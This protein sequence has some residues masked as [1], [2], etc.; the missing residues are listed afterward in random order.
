MD[1]IVRETEDRIPAQ[2]IKGLVNWNFVALSKNMHPTK[3]E[4]SDGAGAPGY[5]HILQLSPQ[6]VFADQVQL[7]Y[8]YTTH[9]FYKNMSSLLIT[10]N[11]RN[12]VLP[13]TDSSD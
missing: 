10:D 6:A 12:S 5:K 9:W 4:L 2:V 7:Q 8:S 13:A 1:K 11:W 3:A